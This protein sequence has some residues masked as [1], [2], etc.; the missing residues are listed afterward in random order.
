MLFHHAKQG[1]SDATCDVSYDGQIGARGWFAAKF[2][3]VAVM[4]W[5]MS[6]MKLR[7]EMVVHHNAL[8]AYVLYTTEGNYLERRES[9]QAKLN[10]IA[11]FIIFG[12]AL[13]VGWWIS[14]SF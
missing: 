11:A 13:G 5:E 10:G 4:V 12:A 2:S 9:S 8:I 14:H 6:Y 1:L 3:M 7:W